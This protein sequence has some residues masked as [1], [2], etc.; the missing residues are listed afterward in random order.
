[1]KLLGSLRELVRVV[2]REDN[3]E[4]TL[5]ANS[6]TTYTAARS[7][8]LP[9]GD[10]NTILVGESNTQTLTNKTIDGDDN[11]VQDL[12]VTAIKT[13]LG[14]A[15]E[16]ILRDASGVPTSA[17]IVNVNI[18]SGAAID[19]AKL[20]DGSVDNTEFQ[21]L[22]TAGS[23]ATGQ[24]VT[25]DGTQLLQNKT[26]DGD[27]N[28]VQDLPLTAIKTALADANKVIRRDA[29][30]VI[31][32]G[33]TLPNSSAIVT[34]DATQ[35]LTNKD[36]DGAT[37][38]NTS[39]ITLPKAGTTTLNGL[40]RKQ[41]TVV[42]DTDTNQLKVDDGSNLI[43]LGASSTAT[44]TT[45]GTVTS[46]TAVIQS[47]IN[48]VSSAD[49]TGTTTDGYQAVLFS[50]GASNRTYTVP[51]ASANIGRR[52]IIRKTDSGTGTVTLARSGSDTISG[53]TSVIVPRQNDFVEILATESNTWVVTQDVITPVIADVFRDAGTETTVTAAGAT[54]TVSAH[55]AFATTITDNYSSI[56]GSGVF[57]VPT[58]MGGIYQ[59]SYSNNYR[60]T[61]IGSNG[62][63]V[64]YLVLIVD[65]ATGTVTRKITQM[66]SLGGTTP[67]GAFGSLNGLLTLTLTAGQTV[68]LYGAIDGG[69]GGGTYTWRYRA[70]KF[71]VRLIKRF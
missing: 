57:T 59:F 12:P 22:G 35:A 42:Y 18:A 39:R 6:S 7:A 20:A 53:L 50:T 56:N 5:D 44:P 1:M 48:S 45:Q 21:K 51:L 26:I 14:D 33:N 15:D 47:S 58:G 38:S 49:Y 64:A 61:S 55:P 67:D 29:S 36:I 37:A 34:T 40:T 27:E 25:T 69:T 54:S 23:N 28:T 19:A 11:T 70:S 10:Q 17:K 30:G 31:Q 46:Y 43:A 16:V 2:F 9:P 68:Q 41:A 52:I 8:E 65:G 71:G 24:L 3:Q 63:S 62:D 4:I 32:S 66:L 13:V 60:I